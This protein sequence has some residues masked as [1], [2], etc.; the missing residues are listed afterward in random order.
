MKIEE[1]EKLSYL[2]LPLLESDRKSCQTFDKVCGQLPSE[3]DQL[4]RGSYN[5]QEAKDLEAK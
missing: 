5:M 1:F 2:P 3:K 4:S